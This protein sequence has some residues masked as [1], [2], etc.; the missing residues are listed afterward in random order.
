MS[1]DRLA[2]PAD[3]AKRHDR[4]RVSDRGY[5][6]GPR[7]LAWRVG[8]AIDTAWGRLCRDRP[9][10][11]S[12]AEAAAAAERVHALDPSVAPYRCLGCAV[13]G[14]IGWHTTSPGADARTP[15]RWGPLW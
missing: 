11:A 9:R 1:G 8:R 3:G 7:R 15:Q 4:R 10:Y 2:V 13:R 14:R 6:A 5:A 12:Y